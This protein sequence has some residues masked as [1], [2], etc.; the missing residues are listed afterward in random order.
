MK[1]IKADNY[2]TW[3]IEESDKS[4]IIDPWLTKQL[5]PKNSLFI[6]R[7]KQFATCLS[8][9]ELSKVG[10][11]IITAPFEDHLNI[12]SIRLFPTKTPIYTSQFVK[13]TI[14]KK[15]VLNP[16]FILNE[17][18]TNIC[19]IQVRALPTSYPYY[20]STFSILFENKN[21]KRIFH[22]G[23]IVNFKYIEEKKIKADVAILTADQVKLFG[24]IT[25][26]MNTMKAINACK[27][28]ESN[29][30]FI[31]GNNPEKTKG[32]IG[33]FLRIKKI[34]TKK[35]SKNIRYYCD[36]GDSIELV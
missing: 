21:N 10:A 25:L 33:K 31:T 13:K 9:D 28:L 5:Q 24:L 22:E 26:G 17:N 34:N 16:I 18:I 23:H 8:E 30:L 2:Q 32:L 36:M 35:L 6:Q 20:R 1:L 4:I 11:I 14:R 29:T 12:E 15:K 19:N 27:L 3:Y 7:T